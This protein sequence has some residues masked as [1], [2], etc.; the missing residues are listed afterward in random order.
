MALQFV[1]F[2]VLGRILSPQAFGLMAIIMIVVSFAELFGK[3]GLSQ[4]LIQR[5]NSTREELS[6]LYWLNAAFG[7]AM[8]VVLSAAAPLVAR[9]FGA[10]ELVSLL[11]VAALS[12][13]LLPFGFLFR[14]LL[15]K[16][17]RLRLLAV[18]DITTA[19]VALAVAVSSAWFLEQG[20]WS[21][22][23]GYLAGSAA[24]TA[25]LVAYGWGATGSRPMLRFRRTDLSGY[26]NFGLYRT[27]ALVLNFFN[28]RVA[29]ILVG[30][31]LGA[32]A[33]GFYTVASSLVMRPIN[34]LNPMLTQVGFPALSRVQDDV[35]RVRRGYLR[36][37]RILMFVASPVLLGVAAVAPTLVPLLLGEQWIES[38]PLVQVLAFYALL[39]CPAIA[40]NSLLTARG[41]ANWGFYWNLATLLVVP[42]VVYA[43]SFA[44]DVV[45]IALA[46]VVVQLPLSVVG[47]RVLIAKLIGP[48][49]GAYARAVWTPVVLAGVM[50]AIVVAVG[51]VLGDLPD[52]ARLAAQVSVGAASYLAFARLFQRKELDGF[53]ELLLRRR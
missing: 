48:C 24:G 51:A 7:V 40:T 5:K 42:P 41:K 53:L 38:V 3:T 45:Y 19:V 18:V 8:F 20:V 37:V 33:L 52:A 21:L 50:A 23:W 39:R 14:A 11:P 34:S 49:L 4:A 30:A 15:Q 26:L 43:S 44:G 36:M 12:F 22:I 35:A 31:L 13:L 10:P 6:S 25:I 46:L 27:G 28:T 16:S 29:Q 17:L 1:Q 47:Y 9:G 2:A 32:Q